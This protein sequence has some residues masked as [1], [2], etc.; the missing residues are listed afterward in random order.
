MS[1]ADF[2]L[3]ASGVFRYQN[4]PCI[5]GLYQ[6]NGQILQSNQ[7]RDPKLFK[8]KRVLVIGGSV[9]GADLACNALKNNAK[10]VYLS[11]TSRPDTR[12]R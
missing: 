8:D 12:N 9:T 3:V 6:F 2:V 1:H 4:V 5:T 7:V 11:A 10:Q